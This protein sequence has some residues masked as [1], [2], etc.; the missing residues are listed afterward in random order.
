M[1]EILKKDQDY[2]LILEK[3][4]IGDCQKI[5]YIKRIFKNY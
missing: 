2:R 4:T 3:I 1:E 5:K